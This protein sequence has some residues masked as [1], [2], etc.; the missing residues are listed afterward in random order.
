MVQH[1]CADAFR[2]RV[3]AV[4]DTTFNL[5]Y[6]L[7]MVAASLAVPDD[8]RS[9]LLLAAAA[10]GFAVLAVGYGIIGGRWARAAGDDIAGPVAAKT[11][12]ED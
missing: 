3:F 10:A 8:G 1:E 11:A 6:V 5:A 2:G 9:P 12:A 4:N 7:G